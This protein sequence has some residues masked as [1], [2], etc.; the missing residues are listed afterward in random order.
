[1]LDV[2]AQYWVYF[3][4]A[5]AIVA[6]VAGWIWSRRGRRVD[7]SDG[8]GG[9]RSTLARSGAAKPAAPDGEVQ[10]PFLVLPPAFGPADNLLEIKGLGP[11][12]AMLLDGLGVTRFEQIAAW[13]ED[14]QKAVD[15]HLGQ[16]QG[17]IVQDRW[18]EQA[19]LL[20]AGKIEEYEAKFG[21]IESYKKVRP[22]QNA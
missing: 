9:I 22:S 2:L 5:L 11:R 21:K 1:M 15:R 13:T 8:T 10:H 7:L 20:A 14:Q 6:G 18:L 19:A 3:V 17:R 12:I 4:V 16:F